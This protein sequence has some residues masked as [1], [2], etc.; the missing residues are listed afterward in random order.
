MYLYRK[1]INHK[2]NYYGFKSWK[3]PR[4]ELDGYFSNIVALNLSVKI[5]ELNEN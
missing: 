5:G 3:R 2:E 1:V 4:L